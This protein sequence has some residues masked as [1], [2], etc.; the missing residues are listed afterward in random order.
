MS[1][2]ASNENFAKIWHCDTIKNKVVLWS[3]KYRLLNILDKCLMR[4]KIVILQN[5]YI[6]SWGI[7]IWTAV[8]YAST[9]YFPRLIKFS[10]YNLQPC[11]FSCQETLCFWLKLRHKKN[12]VS[13]LQIKF[14][15]MIKR[16]FFSEACQS[17]ILYFGAWTVTDIR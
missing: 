17:W 11:W 16:F 4:K 1:L 7:Y 10:R 3:L 5:S 2:R 9:H 8:Q 14:E 15:V 13:S 6:I 12:C